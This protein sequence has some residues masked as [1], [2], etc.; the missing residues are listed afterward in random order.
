MNVSRREETG[1]T[2]YSINIEFET[3]EEAVEMYNLFQ[4]APVTNGLRCTNSE[5]LR[6]AIGF[7]KGGRAWANFQ[8][9]LLVSYRDYMGDKP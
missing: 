7:N 6:K 8:K 5:K 2:P 1:F 9:D 3:V 4:F